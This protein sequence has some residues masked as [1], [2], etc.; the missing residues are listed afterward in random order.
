MADF[1]WFPLYVKDWLAGTYDMTTEQRGAY[2]QLLCASWERGG[3]PLESEACR[4][5]AVCTPPEWRRIWPTV[6][7][8]WVEREG[9]LINER[10]EKERMTIAARSASARTSAAVRWQSVRN[11]N[12]SANAVRSECYSQSQSDPEA[13]PDSDRDSLALVASNP[14]IELSPG[15]LNAASASLPAAWNGAIRGQPAL[16]PIVGGYDRAKVAWALKSRPDLD[17]WT[18]VFRQVAASDFCCGRAPLRDGRAFVADFWWCLT[19]AD[20]IAAG[21]YDNRAAASVADPNA[22]AVA[23][24]KLAV[25]RRMS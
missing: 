20:E 23:A 5:L 14:P 24:A 9:R 18:E 25:R 12:A 15:Q 2:M 11:A 4:K 22:A 16:V 17:W 19:H 7:A 8:K 10:Q 1:P 13:D 6:A 21:R 3:L